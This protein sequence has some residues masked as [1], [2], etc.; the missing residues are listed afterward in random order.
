MSRILLIEDNEINRDMLSRRLERK[1]YKVIVAIN[2][3]EGVAKTKSEQP[4]L[5]LMDMHLPVLDG[6]EATRQ[7]KANPQTQTI[8]VIALTA[9]A[10][11]GEREKALAAGCDEYDTKPVDF[12]RLLEKIATLLK[13]VA[14]Y[15]PEILPSNQVQQQMLLTQLRR[16][17]EPMIYSIL[18]YSDMLLDILHKQQNSAL[19]S[20]LQKIYVS[21]MQLLQLVQAILNP[22]LAE[23]Q[24]QEIDLC[25]PSLRRELLTPLS[26]IIGYCE[27][28]LEEAT[29][30]IILDLEQIQ[31]AAQGLLSKVTSLDSLIKQ[32][33]QSILALDV[34]AAG[35]IID[36][37]SLETL[38]QQNILP[39]NRFLEVEDCRVLVVDSNESNCTLLVRQLQRYNYQVAIATTSDRALQ[40]LGTMP[41][42]LIVLNTS[43]LNLLEQLQRHEKWQ[44][45]PVLLTATLDEMEQVI[46]GIAMGAVDYMTHPFQSVLLH[47][48]VTACLDRKQLRD[49]QGK[50]DNLFENAPV[51]VYQATAEG[52]FQYVNP[53]LVKILGYPDATTLIEAVTNISSQIYVDCNQY[54]E[55]KA[56]LKKHD[57]V[58]G[59]EYQSWRQ[60]GSV[61]W[62]SEHTWSVRDS[63]EQLLYYK[64]IVEEITQR[65]LAEADLKQRLVE[66]HDREHNKYAQQAQEIVQT[67]YFQQLQ[68]N[69]AQD[70]QTF[71]RATLPIK[72]LL[73]E[74]NEL[75]SDMLSRRLQR[76]GYKVMI[77]RDGA[78]GVSKAIS[79]LPHIILMDISLPVIDGCEATQQIKA[80]LLTNRIPIIALTAHAMTGD[81]EKA[82][83]SGCDDYDTKPIDLSRLL[84]KIE[85]CLKP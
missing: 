62:V 30:D 5:V 11:A 52:F 65:K 70:C 35:Q 10:I 75:N 45:I 15:S 51:G 1:G 82:I 38:H 13:P 46:Q 6:W 72:V 3:A 18:G 33:L 53:A 59:F 34:S 55:F 66:P 19:R 79:E 69:E 32:H 24:Q 4:D 28:L 76:Y 27:M 8:P 21:G 57:R 39:A 41:Y 2:G 83:A 84:N 68:P 17:L 12:P 44:D 74:D 73:V 23:I 40:T 16:D 31:T 26:T 77:A 36:R 50:F 25:A 63:S 47:Y 78:D 29:D 48:K 85:A 67:N 71:D 7:I 14:M 60:D 43:E 54:A 42:N 9:D 80:N 64:G 20:D 81:R 37:F 22:I 58:T 56:L 61:I 49:R